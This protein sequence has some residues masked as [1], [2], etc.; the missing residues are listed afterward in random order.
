MTYTPHDIA[1]K[2][3]DDYKKRDLNE[4][5]TRHQI[6]DEVIHGVL[7]W[8]KELTKCES[9]IDPGFADYRLKKGNGDDLVFLEA[10]KAGFF[11][12]LPSNFNKDHTSKHIAVKTLL[13]DENTRN[14]IEQVRDYCMEEGCEFAG[15]TNGNEWIFFKTFERG[16]NWRNLKAFVVIN[17]KFFSSNFVEATNYFGYTS[18]KDG[19]LKNILGSISRKNREIF[20]PKD[21]IASYDQEVNANKYSREL[22]PLSKKYFGVIEVNDP[23]FMEDCYVNQR[24]Y[25][26]AFDSFRTIIRDSLTPYL[27]EYGVRDFEDDKDGGQL[28]N[29][30]VRNLGS[31]KKGEVIVLFGGKGSGKSTFLKKLLYHKPPEIISQNAVISIIDLLNTPEEERIIHAVIWDKIVENLDVNGVLSSDRAKLLDLFY[32]RFDIAKKQILCGL[33]EKSENYNIKLN[34]LVKEW[35]A[36]KKYVAKQLVDFWKEEHKGC[37]IVI[38]N[39]DQFPHSLQDFCFTTSHEIANSLDCLVIVSMREERFH[40]SRMHG[41]LDA[42]QNAGFHISSPVI[43][44]VFDKRIKYVLSILKSIDNCKSLFGDDIQQ[45][46]INACIK[47]F[48]IFENEFNK[49]GDSPLN[50]FLTACAHGNIRLALELFRDLVKSGYINV[51]EMISVDNLWVLRI[52]QVL[53]PLMIPYRFFYDEDQSSIPNIFQVRSKTNGS[54]FTGLRILKRLSE[55]IDPSNPFYVS[56]SELKDYFSENFNMVEDFEKNL[57]YFLKRDL[58]EANNRIDF[59]CEDVDSIKITTY[60]LYIFKTLSSYFTY[61]EL[62]STDCGYYNERVAGEMVALSNE[63]YKLFIDRKTTERVNLRLRKAETFIEYL[64]EEE[65]KENEFFNISPASNFANIMKDAFA[66]EKEIVLRSLSR[67]RD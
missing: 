54:H 45:Y 50:E 57:D 60:G 44:A 31:Q 52:H 8:P 29:R 1:I 14:A 26:Q 24:D 10:K 34:E 55:G 37:V 36:D 42:Y 58:V 22:R 30:I 7:C 59:Y 66:T 5:D 4:A 32:D 25:N 64:I 65:Q 17:N 28:G 49:D 16:K 23:Q 13:T 67:R 6:I 41:T 27:E 56:I 15:I 47:L 33:D 12:N 19:S 35:L 63:E 21:K 39:T 9:F 40:A 46:K 51:D 3:V 43:Q 18:I 11:F 38:D 20:F 53:K 48:E 2:I 62:I 61:I